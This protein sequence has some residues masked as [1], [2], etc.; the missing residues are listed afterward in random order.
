MREL[1][2][3]HA[4]IKRKKEIAKEKL[5]PT[6]EEVMVHAT[7]EMEKIANVK[8]FE[9]DFGEDW[10]P[11]ESET[12]LF[13]SKDQNLRGKIRELELIYRT[14]RLKDVF[15][16]YYERI[17]EDEYTCMLFGDYEDELEDSKS[18]LK[19]KFSENCK[20]YGKLRK[21]FHKNYEQCTVNKS[22]KETLIDYFIE[23]NKDIA[24][25]G[26]A[27]TPPKT[28]STGVE[29]PSEKS[30]IQIAYEEDLKENNRKEAAFKRE[31]DIYKRKKELGKLKRIKNTE[32]PPHQ[33]YGENPKGKKE[34]FNMNDT[35]KKGQNTWKYVKKA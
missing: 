8:D 7:R 24:K 19:K 15:H 34:K 11:D 26:A 35:S 21:E 14:N 5:I 23:K 17:Q 25:K 22:T 13:Y 32:S 20:K 10:C 12:I 1:R 18:I 30:P 29:A 2:K 9:K 3:F 28:Q 16:E 6:S 4:S 33:D 31:R 27:Q